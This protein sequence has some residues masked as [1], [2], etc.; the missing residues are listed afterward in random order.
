MNDYHDENGNVLNAHLAW[1]KVMDEVRAIHKDSVNSFQKFNFRGIDAVMN[2]VGPIFRKYGVSCVPS[3]IVEAKHRDF[4]GGKEKLQHEAIVTVEYRVTGPDGSTF[5]GES[6]GEAS[7]TSDKATTQAMSVAYRTFLLQ[8]L[9]MPTD[10]PDP[11]ENTV[12]RAPEVPAWQQAG[13]EQEQAQ[14]DAWESLIGRA[15][16][17]PD[18][19]EKDDL[20]AWV[21][22]QGYKAQTLTKDGANEFHRRLQA[23]QPAAEGDPVKGQGWKS[24]AERT[25]TAK[26]ITERLAAL[27]A[28][29]SEHVAEAMEGYGYRGDPETLDRETANKI[30]TDLDEAEELAKGDAS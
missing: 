12:D 16:E 13:W 4:T 7:D 20:K 11:D 5:L 21:K 27:P 18:G 9:T 8:G 2:S 15:G 17:L 1:M 6:I 30:L 3:R 28:F 22:A 23:L 10:S 29:E 26:R 25:R 14:T 19:P 24:K